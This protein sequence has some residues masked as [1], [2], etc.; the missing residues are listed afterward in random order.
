MQTNETL[1]CLFSTNQ[2][3]HWG[4]TVNLENYAFQILLKPTTKSGPVRT[5]S[6]RRIISS[7]LFSEVWQLVIS[8]QRFSCIKFVNWNPTFKKQLI[9]NYFFPHSHFKHYVQVIWGELNLEPRL[10]NIIWQSLFWKTQAS[11]SYFTVLIQLG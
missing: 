11:V 2:L 3:F 5:H 6:Y 7:T 4:L 1:D 10:L 8:L 9:L